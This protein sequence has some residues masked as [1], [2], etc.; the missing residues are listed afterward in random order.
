MPW[1]EIK[2]VFII[3]LLL[4]LPGWAL[5]AVTGYWRRWNPLQRWFLAACLGIA[6]WPVLYYST[7]AI[8][9]FLRIGDSKI[10]LLLVISAGLIFWKLRD[11][12]KEHFKLGKWGWLVLGILAATLFTRLFLAQEYPYPGWTDSLH[13][14]LITDLT[15]TTGKL[16]LTLEPY[17][18]L[19]LDQYHLG[20]YALTAPLQLLG[21]IPAHTAVLWMGQFLNG[22]CGIGLFLLLDK[23]V[24]R[25]AG[26]ISMVVVGLLSF[27]PA[28]YF[29][30]GRFT[31]LSAQTILI[32]AF[33]MYWDAIETGISAGKRKS[34]SIR[35]AYL[36]TA[37]TLAAV[38]L[39]H[40]R[41]A[42]YLLPLLFI[43]S[44][45]LFIKAKGV[46]RK[47]LLLTVG[48]LAII[49][50]VFILPAFIPA[51]RSY[52]QVKAPD[53]PLSAAESAQSAETYFGNFDLNTYFLIGT[54][55]W[56][57]VLALLGL[58]SGIINRKTRA[59]TIMTAIWVL[60]LVGEGFLYRTGIGKLAFTNMTGI[61]ILGYLPAGILTGVLAETLDSFSK[62]KLK[63]NITGAMLF[64]V[65]MAGYVGSF[66]RVRSIEDYRQ[67]MTPADEKAMAWVEKNTPTNARFGINTWFWLPKAPHGSD[68][69][70]W[71][72]YFANRKTST[73]VMISEFSPDHQEDIESSQAI[74]EL[75]SNPTKLQLVCDL[76]ISYLYSSAKAPFNGM[77]FNFTEMISTGNARM[78]YDS[79]GV[80]ILEICP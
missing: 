23:K 7:R 67:F 53:V 66:D 69:G 19:P 40:F 30:W 39:F 62:N 6:F 28:L 13:H 27:Q 58:V 14:T 38:A 29:G 61:M 32:T 75:Y 11:G 68:A 65:I 71:L 24:S 20:F 22:L 33:L 36:L 5:L 43:L 1:V 48:I 49:S 60:C 46:E 31:Q 76:G 37:L 9:P 10:V 25:L 54:D 42:A 52:T 45:Y 77:D 21:R 74:V 15:A 35:N 59:I 26:L 34:S 51:I 78:V 50:L 56:L 80:Q 4:L 17:D 70:Y 3:L 57:T 44:V 12:W 55:R 8:L 64:I 47:Q 72:P 79:D 63:I 2:T 41:V 18:N 73:S 16:P